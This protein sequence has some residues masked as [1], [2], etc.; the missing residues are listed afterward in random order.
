MIRSTTSSCLIFKISL[1]SE[2]TVSNKRN[3]LA[4]S[5]VSLITRL[6][7]SLFRLTIDVLISII[8]FCLNDGPLAQLVEHLAF[9][10]RV[11]GS[12]PTRLIQL[13]Q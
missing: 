13:N 11:V 8:A 10:Q 9:N 3:S 7:R 4:F 6:S 2:R 1:Q 12:S 5:R